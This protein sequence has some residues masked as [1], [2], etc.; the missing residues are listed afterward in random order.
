MSVLLVLSL[1]LAS[2]PMIFWGF[3]VLLFFVSGFFCMILIIGNNLIVGSQHGWS[4]AFPV[5]FHEL[6]HHLNELFNYLNVECVTEVY[7]W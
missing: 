2:E 6:F 7:L 3:F 1:L 5:T 4:S